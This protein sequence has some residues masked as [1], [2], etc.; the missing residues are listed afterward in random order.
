MILELFSVNLVAV[1][2]AYDSALEKPIFEVVLISMQVWWKE[3]T[4]NVCVLQSRDFVLRVWSH[5]KSL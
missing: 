5:Y 3:S 4:G 2:D 1:S